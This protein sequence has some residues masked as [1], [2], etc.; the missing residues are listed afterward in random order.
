MV[1]FN[2]GSLCWEPVVLA[3]KVKM[4]KFLVLSEFSTFY[5]KNYLVSWVLLCEYIKLVVVSPVTRAIVFSSSLQDLHVHVPG[6]S[7]S[8][9]G[10][11]SPS[12]LGI[13]EGKGH[14]WVWAPW[15]IAPC[16]LHLSVE[17]G[18]RLGSV[19][20]PGLGSRCPQFGELCFLSSERVGLPALQSIVCD[21]I[22][23]SVIHLLF[24]LLI[25]SVTGKF[26]VS[27]LK[28]AHERLTSQ[29]ALSHR[30]RTVNA[31]CPSGRIVCVLC[32]TFCYT[33]N[34]CCPC[35]CYSLFVHFKCLVSI[36]P[37]PT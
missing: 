27:D 21:F 20:R 1:L 33:L 5:F 34:S 15:F 19:P 22:I 26:L 36:N 35:S 2:G 18:V 7:R 25:L 37:G 32:A 24:L 9:G 13:S 14:V 16:P 8:P 23:M 28:N 17:V 31:H 29:V 3:D 12:T 30:S 6:W 10:G 11:W 4:Q